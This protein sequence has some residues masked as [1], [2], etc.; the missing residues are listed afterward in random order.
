MELSGISGHCE[1]QHILHS[2]SF[3]IRRSRLYT[4]INTGKTNGDA[5]VGVMLNLYRP[6]S[7]DIRLFK[8]GSGE[9]LDLVQTR[10]NCIPS[11]DKTCRSLDT[12]RGLRV[13][14]TR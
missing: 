9:R 11:S 2:I 5:L 4:L 10:I 6:S 12:T 8:N 14:Y 7:K 13:Q 1:G 3:R